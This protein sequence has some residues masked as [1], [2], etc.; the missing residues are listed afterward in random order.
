MIQNNQN[1]IWHNHPITQKEREQ[2]HGHRSIVLWFTGFSGSGKSTIAGSLEKHLYQ[3]G[4]NSYLLDGDNLRHGLCHDLNFSVHDRKE[5][6]RRIGEVA[7]LMID[8]GLIVLTA[9]ISPYY[10]ERKMVRNLIGSESFLE[11]FI[12]TPLSMCEKR[13]PKGL[14][15]KARSG[16]LTNFTGIDSEYQAPL[17]PDIHLD[18]EKSITVLTNEVL[19]FL[20]IRNIIQY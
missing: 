2:L 15:K 14:Y 8:A 11:I 18:G 1:L 3:M 19:H 6:I 13:D 5:N 17:K 10:E 9:L 12:D 7:K 20:K 16:A 4:I